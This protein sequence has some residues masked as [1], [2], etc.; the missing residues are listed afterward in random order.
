[1][2]PVH[3]FNLFYEHVESLDLEATLTE[4]VKGCLRLVVVKRNLHSS[5]HWFTLITS[6]QHNADNGYWTGVLKKKG[7]HGMNMQV[8]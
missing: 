4:D 3:V 1:M 2:C 8:Y 5:T 7:Q 6:I